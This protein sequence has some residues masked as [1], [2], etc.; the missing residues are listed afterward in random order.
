VTGPPAAPGIVGE[1]QLVGG[2]RLVRVVVT[3]TVRA[4]RLDRH[5]I[6]VGVERDAATTAGEQRRR[7]CV[8]GGAVGVGARQDREATRVD[9]DHGE[10]VLDATG[11]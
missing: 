3:G 2:V 11:R 7:P 6:S 5:G 1:A 10:L 9:A 8:D 4:A